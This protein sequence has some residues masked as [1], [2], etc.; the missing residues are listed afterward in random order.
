MKPKAEN[1]RLELTPEE[2][3]KIY[4]EEKL[5][6]ERYSINKLTPEERKKIYEEELVRAEAQEKAKDNV[7]KRKR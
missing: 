1:K 6:K 2:K 5:E 4:E 7:E 3:K